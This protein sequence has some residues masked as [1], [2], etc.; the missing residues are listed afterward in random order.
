VTGL[1]VE[2]GPTPEAKNLRGL[3]GQPRFRDLAF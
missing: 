3:A 2:A 1:L